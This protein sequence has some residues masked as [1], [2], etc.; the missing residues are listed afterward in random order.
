M[1]IAH[2]AVGASILYFLGFG[3]GMIVRPALIKNFDLEWSAPTGKT[4]VRCYYGA[5]SVGLSVFMGYLMY[6]HMTLPALT[7]MCIF[8]TSVFVMRV[9]GTAID[10]SWAS[11]YTKLAIPTEALFVLALGGAR[12]LA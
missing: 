8:A 5:L 7:G 10:K 4:E 1:T 12:I 2:I 6:R 3:I 9:I 11:S